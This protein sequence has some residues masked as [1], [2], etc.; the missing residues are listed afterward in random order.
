VKVID[1]NILLYAVNRDVEQHAR[2]RQW[3]DATL[4]G[5]EPV[6]M[7]WIVILGFLRIATSARVFSRPLT[8]AEAVGIVDA[9]LDQPSVVALV[10]GPEHWS[11]LRTLLLEADAGSGMTSDAHLAAIA[12]ENGAELC[13]ADA[14]FRRFEG[15]RWRNPLVGA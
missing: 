8:S 4:S 13:S 10:P 15:I 3:L 11:I 5:D 6:A 12:I 14:D 7:P 2:A 9:W 1:L